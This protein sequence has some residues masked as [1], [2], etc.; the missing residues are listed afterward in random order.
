[1]EASSSVYMKLPMLAHLDQ[2]RSFD[3]RVAV[4]L[5]PCMMRAL[6]AVLQ[7]DALLREKI[8]CKI[9]LFCS[10]A[11][12]KR[13]S[14]FALDH[15]RIP[16][17]GAKRLYYRRGHWRGSAGVVYKDGSVR[18]FSYTKSV[19]A[20]KNAYFF[21]DKSCL[22]CKDQFASYADISFGDIWLAQVKK[23]PVKYTGFV[24]R[25]QMRALTFKYRGRRWNHALAGFLA[26]RNRQ[27][28]IEHP[29]LLK[30]VPMRAIYYYMC[31]IRVL[32]SW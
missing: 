9:G 26:V 31:A 14:E 30:R 2:I 32:L 19:C 6:D 27:F 5:T 7:K 17:A 12:D 25:S 1:M 13:A 3:G 24:V 15:C 8:V 23:A 21:I 22:S 29:E 18:E 16:R 11:H 10:G 4:V 28:S 20:Y